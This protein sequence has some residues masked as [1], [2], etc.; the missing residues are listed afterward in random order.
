M[1][2]RFIAS[3]NRDVAAVYGFGSFLRGGNYNDIDI[4]VVAHPACK[5]HLAAFYTFLEG[6]TNYSCY[7]HVEFHLTFLMYVEYLERPLLEM[8]N[9]TIL[10]DQTER[11]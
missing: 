3:A 4:L 9:L 8:D 1:A 7:L 5:D 11:E 10:F 2:I 6:L